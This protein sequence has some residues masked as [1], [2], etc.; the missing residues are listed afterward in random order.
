MDLLLY[1]YASDDQGTPG[2]LVFPG[3]QNL[4]TIELPWRDNEPWFSC[5]PVEDYWIEKY[6]SEKYLAWCFRVLEVKSREDI[7]L[8]RANFA[9]DVRKGF[10]S[11]LS[12]CIAPGLRPGTLAG[13]RAVLSSKLAMA[14]MLRIIGDQPVRLRIMKGY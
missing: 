11:D 14:E 1:R 4:W 8:H 2:L 3:Y 12:G 5:I 6:W 9:G 10:R 7:S 13:Q